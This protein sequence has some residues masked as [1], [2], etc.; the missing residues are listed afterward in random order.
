MIREARTLLKPALAL[1]LLAAACGGRPAAVDPGAAPAW[2]ERVAEPRPATERPPLLVLLHGLGGD[3]ADLLRL[4][5]FVD[6]RFLVVSVRAPRRWGAGY[7]WFPMD[8]RSDGSFR[9]HEDDARAVEL[10]LARWLAAAPARLGTDPARTYVL[11]FSQG[12]MLTVGLLRTHPAEVAGAVVLSGSDVPE[13]FP[14][15]APRAAVTRVPLF[16]GHGT[17][18]D[19]LPVERGRAIRDAFDDVTR[20]L[21]YREYPIRHGVDQGEMADV[22]AWLTE[23]LDAASPT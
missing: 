5:P 3:A 18:D 8:V 10:D 14:L 13:A 21:T 9:I 11:G 2:T 1:A 6:G 4:A 19:V 12:A 7:S 15:A 17:E 20:D 16:V 23:R 22:S